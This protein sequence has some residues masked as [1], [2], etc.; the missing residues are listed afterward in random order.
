MHYL[1]HFYLSG[2]SHSSIL[3]NFIGEIKTVNGPSI[4]QEDIQNGIFI[5]NAIDAFT[6]KHPVV[7]KSRKRLSPKFVKYSSTIIDVFYDHFLAANW[8]DY[9][10][11]PLEKFAVNRYHTLLEYQNILP[12]K[13]KCMLQQMIADNWLVK[14]KTLAGVNEAKTKELEVI[15][16]T[17]SAQLSGAMFN[18]M[19]HYSEFKND[20][21]DFFPELIKFVKMIQVKEKSDSGKVIHQLQRMTA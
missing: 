21:N 15:K 2:N 16:S 4:Y 7:V 1:A 20:F 13:A 9:H 3:G 12:Y 10:T 17:V 18:L 8:D 5:H 6:D 19:D 14:Y 11:T